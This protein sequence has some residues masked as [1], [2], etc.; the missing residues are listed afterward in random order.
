M[1]ERIDNPIC[2][3]GIDLIAF[4]YHETSEREAQDFERHLA[5][6]SECAREL[7]AF[8]KI[9]EGVVAWR[10]ESLGISPI[11]DHESSS[12]VFGR[13]EKPSALIALRQ[14]FEL[15]PL[16]LK[17]AVA[18]ASVLFCV[19]A[20]LMV[21]SLR[22]KPESTVV[23]D[24]KV[25][26]DQELKAKVEEGIQARLRELNA[27]QGNTAREESQRSPVIV[28]NEKRRLREA[29]GYR[30]KTQRAPLT[31]SEREQLAADLRLISP[32]E[33]SDLDLLDEEL[34]R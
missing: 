25:Y 3:R 14:F 1:E 32:K 16:W 11:R 22:E 8:R 4:L 30:V 9:R 18:F 20:V 31:R 10:Q 17:G 6:C 7:V 21:A 2:E 29:A 33:D 27:Q 26:S 23:R 28:Q 12:A 34:N 24:G 19:A 15:S 13:S 5:K